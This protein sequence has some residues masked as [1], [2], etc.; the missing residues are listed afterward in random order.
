MPLYNCFNNKIYNNIYQKHVVKTI[1][2]DNPN[3]DASKKESEENSRKITKY[4]YTIFDSQDSK[5]NIYAFPVKLFANYTIAIDCHKGIEMFCGLY[6]TTLDILKLSDDSNTPTSLMSKTY[7]KID[8]AIFN[9]PFLYDCLDISKWQETKTQEA[10]SDSSTLTCWD[11]INREQDL[12]LFIKVPTTCKSSIVVL[13]GDYRK[14]NQV[15]YAP[16]SDNV[17]FPKEIRTIKQNG[18]IINKEFQARE[19]GK[20]VYQQNQSVT[21][22]SKLNEQFEPIT[23]LQLLALNTGESYPFSTRLIEYLAGSVITPVDELPDNIKRVQRVMNLNKYYFKV[24]GLWED[25]MQP[26]IY[27][28]L[29]NAGP[30]ETIYICDDPK[31]AEFGQEVKLSPNDTDDTVKKIVIDKRRGYQTRL[32]LSTKSSLFDILGYVDKDAEKW[33]TSW[34]ADKKDIKNTEAVLLDNIHS[35]DIY[36]GLYDI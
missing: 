12:K 7:R 1:K 9:Q 20:W 11:I 23:K 13:E 21:N 19:I 8:K 34:S 3:F 17:V 18:K 6:K 35:V 30:F 25:K 2:V 29:M 14:Y 10:F 24:N 36:D 26:I 32:G 27:D 33:Y 4:E 5:Y 22:F 31:K 15:K 16:V 28:H